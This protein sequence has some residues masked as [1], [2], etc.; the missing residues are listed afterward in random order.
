MYYVLHTAS[1]IWK[2]HVENQGKC[3][4]QKIQCFRRWIYNLFHDVQTLNVLWITCW[5]WKLVALREWDQVVFISYKYL[6][7][8]ISMAATTCIYTNLHVLKYMM[9]SDNAYGIRTNVHISISFRSKI[10]EKDIFFIVGHTGYIKTLM[11]GILMYM[12]V[13]TSSATICRSGIFLSWLVNYSHRLK[14]YH[15]NDKST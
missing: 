6:M 14:K 12:H 4:K 1:K 11:R 13:F 2:K 9:S 7:Q 8:S 3:N 5:I 10:W 15:K